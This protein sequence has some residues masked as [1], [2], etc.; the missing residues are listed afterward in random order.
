MGC[1]MPSSNNDGCLQNHKTVPVLDVCTFY[2]C[3]V[4]GLLHAL[5]LFQTRAPCQ[6]SYIA[7]SSLYVAGRVGDR[8]KLHCRG[9][10]LNCAH[11]RQIQVVQ[12]C[13]TATFRN[14]APTSPARV[15]LPSLHKRTGSAADHRRF[16]GA[17]M[18]AV[19]GGT[20]RAGGGVQQAGRARNLET[21]RGHRSQTVRRR[22]ELVVRCSK[23][24]MRVMP[25]KLW[26]AV[27]VPSPL[28]RLQ[29]C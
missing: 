17:P 15:N 20:L 29:T 11:K 13:S 28:V 22:G 21:A 14:D 25:R 4:Y 24:G 7:F 8:W 5:T 2:R 16:I 19:C 6:S 12:S 18:L 1:D 10:G 27:L 3:I 9:T 23:W 26:G